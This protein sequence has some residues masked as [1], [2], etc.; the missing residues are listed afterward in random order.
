MKSEAI[1]SMIPAIIIRIAIKN[2]GVVNCNKILPILNVEASNAYKAITK[3][4][5]RFPVYFL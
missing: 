3:T 5:N 2:K 1:K 4:M